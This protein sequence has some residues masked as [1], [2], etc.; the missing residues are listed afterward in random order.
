MDNFVDGP[1]E[2]PT[3]EQE[4]RKFEKEFCKTLTDG[5]KGAIQE[6]DGGKMQKTNYF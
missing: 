5:T 6:N 1:L 2:N 4:F 3:P